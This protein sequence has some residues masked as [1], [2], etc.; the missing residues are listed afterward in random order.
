MVRATL[1]PDPTVFDQLAHAAA[2]VCTCGIVMGMRLR[3][4]GVLCRQ[5][6][7]VVT[8]LDLGLLGLSGGLPDAMS[9][10]V[11]LQVSAVPVPHSSL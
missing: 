11:S 5:P 2:H 9:A 10:L 6:A 4:Y 7:D 1:T 3:R 8:E